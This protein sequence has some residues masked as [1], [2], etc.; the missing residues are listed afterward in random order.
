MSHAQ[1]TY[2]GVLVNIDSALAVSGGGHPVAP[3]L[4]ASDGKLYGTTL[5]CVE[6]GCPFGAVFSFNP[7]TSAFVL[8]HQFTG[9]DGS[10]PYGRLV[11]ASDGKLYGTTFNGGDNG[12]NGGVIY[13]IDP[14]S[15]DFAVVHVFNGP[16]EGQQPYD[17]LVEGPDGRLYGT[18]VTAGPAIDGEQTG[19]VFAWDP[20]SGALEVLH[21]FGYSGGRAPYGSVIFGQD[22]KLY[23]TTTGW[24]NETYQFLCGSVFSL[25]PVSHAF[26]T[27]RFFSCGS[28]RGVPYARLVRANGLLYGSMTDTGGAVFSVNPENDAYAIVHAFNGGPDG[29]SPQA[30]LVLGS[31][32]KLYGTTT[33]VAPAFVTLPGT[34]FEL[35]PATGVLTTLHTF[36][37]PPGDGNTRYG[38][39]LMQANDGTFY[40]VTNT[41]GT[42]DAGIIFS[43][44]VPGVLPLTVNAGPDQ[45]LTANLIGRASATLAAV[46]SGGAAPYAYAWTTEAVVGDADDLPLSLG[47]TANIQVGL[48]L[49][50]FTLRVTV[51]DAT[52]ATASATTHVTVQLPVTA[53]LPGPQ[54]PQ[55]P[56]GETG[57][58]GPQGPKGDTG[59]P[60]PQGSQGPQGLQ[61]PQGTQGPQGPQ[62]PIGPAGP[63]GP[64]NTQLWTTFLSGAL[65]SV[66]VHGRFTPDGNLT[67]TR[68]Q[69]QVPSA[70]A[71]C[72][73][74]AVLRVTNGTAAGTISL[75]L[76][77]S[78]NDTGAISINY[79][80]GVPIS[81][82]VGV[83]AAGCRTTPQD[84]NVVVQYKAR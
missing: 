19:T 18:A 66:G 9:P 61:G 31:N 15:G 32:G 7:S 14:A 4:Q 33:G 68:V 69:A 52:G 75:P 47:T 65:T 54:G 35:D 27:I 58:V 24:R 50:A 57:A 17:G 62:G 59:A 36:E 28:D 73:T 30:A 40:G 60:G 39:G 3:L 38:S 84:A 80:A 83:A 82:G 78:S 70:P 43:A 53:G 2:N 55:G 20:S 44:T 67:V 12:T 77:G 23:G 22:G 45:T 10:L 63:A 1:A 46:A 79:A 6:G 13:S 72:R 26:H 71:G 41:G 74:T 16:V 37:G 29:S 8:L 5:G 21:A 48:P 81:V 42:Y 11:Q 49:G 34:L 56:Q 76:P 51:T 64:S 25:D